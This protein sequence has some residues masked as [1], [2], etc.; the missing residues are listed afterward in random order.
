VSYLLD[1]CIISELVRRKPARR[2]VRWVEEA[3]EE[4]L[5]LSVLSVGEIEKGIAKLPATSRRRSV[6]RRWV[7]RDLRVRFAE[8]LLPISAEIALRWGDLSGT[9]EREGAPLPVIDALL[10]ATAL[11]HGLTVVTRNVEDIGRAGADVLNPWN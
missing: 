3:D 2:V 11:S 9:A 1:T 5:Y 8:R 10:A 4:A 6:L 7:E